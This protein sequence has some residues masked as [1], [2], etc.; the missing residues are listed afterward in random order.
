MIL[1]STPL[2][3]YSAK[4]RIA[5]ALLDLAPELRAPPDG[6]YR[7]AAYRAIVSLGTVPALVE[8]DFVLSESDAIAEYLDETHPPARLLPGPPRQR[9]WIRFLSRF[10]DLHLEP[11]LRALFG[12]VAPSTRDTAIV[13]A[14]LAEIT[15]LVTILDSSIDPI[16]PFAAGP[17]PTLADCGF[18]PSLAIADA[19]LPA[20]GA[21]ELPLT[22]RLRLWR[23]ALRQDPRIE[24]VMAPYRDEIQR[25]LATKR[26]A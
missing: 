17:T 15:R 16:G 4:L 24:T 20:I 22:P 2:S 11:H 6:S 9:A 1:Y 26:S 7:S 23:A 10:H 21:A 5:C 19:L 8:G 3:S 18:A 25:W 12:Q 13:A 14:R